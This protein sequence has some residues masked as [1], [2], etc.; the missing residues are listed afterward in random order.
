MRQYTNRSWLIP[1]AVF[2]IALLLRLIPLLYQPFDGLYGQDA[3]AYFDFAAAIRNML[4]TGESQEPSSGDWVTRQCW[5]GCSLSVGAQ[6]PE[7]RRLP[8]S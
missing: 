8:A 5:Q 6:R 3:Y 7:S 2:I 4:L 1:F